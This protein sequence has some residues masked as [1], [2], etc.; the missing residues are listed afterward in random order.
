MNNNIEL[1]TII[2]RKCERFE[3]PVIDFTTHKYVFETVKVYDDR[4]GAYKE[5]EQPKITELTQQEKQ[6][7]IEQEQKVQAEQELEKLRVRR[8]KECFTHID[9]AGKWDNYTE[10]QKSQLRLWRKQWLDV[11]QTKIIPQ[12]PYWLN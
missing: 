6:V 4:L 10:D 8:A 3:V 11:T 5:I 1:T 7:I 12:K 2:N 9:P